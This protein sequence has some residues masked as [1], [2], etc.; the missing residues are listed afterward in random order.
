MKRKIWT[1]LLKWKEEKQNIKSL[2]MLGVRQS[3]KHL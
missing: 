3:G 1:E 2:M